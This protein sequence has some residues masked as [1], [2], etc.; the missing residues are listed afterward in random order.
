MQIRLTLPDHIAADPLRN[1]TA[2]A[3]LVR[4]AIIEQ[5]GPAIRCP[6]CGHR[7]P[8]H[9]QSCGA[10]HDCHVDHVDNCPGCFHGN[11]GPTS[12]H[13]CRHFGRVDV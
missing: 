1:P 2:L 12:H 13:T 10:T 9:Y 11:Y 8:A 5:H 7:T 4:D 6:D 3:L